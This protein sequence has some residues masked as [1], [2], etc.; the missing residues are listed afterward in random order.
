LEGNTIDEIVAVIENEAGEKLNVYMWREGGTVGASLRINGTLHHIEWLPA[1][2]IVT[3]YVVDTDP[4]YSPETDE[5]GYCFL[6]VPFS[7]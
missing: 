6:V 4:D 3:N 5:L 1:S 7:T 2:E